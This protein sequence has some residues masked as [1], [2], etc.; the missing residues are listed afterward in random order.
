MKERVDAQVYECQC[1][2]SIHITRLRVRAHTLFLSFRPLPPPFALAFALSRALSLYLSVCLRLCVFHYPCLGHASAPPVSLSLCLCVSLY[3][4]VSLFVTA[5]HTRA[6]EKA[7]V[8][9]LRLVG[10]I[11]S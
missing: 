2:T 1:P 5:V 10:S 3:Q 7:P 6:Q 9:W 8:G 11:K 4:S